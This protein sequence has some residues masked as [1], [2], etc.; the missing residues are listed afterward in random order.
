MSQVEGQEVIGLDTISCV[1]ENYNACSFYANTLV[2]ET[3][4]RN[5]VIAT[6]GTEKFMKA[7]AKA[8]I[9][10]NE[11]DSRMDV[12]SILCIREKDKYSCDLEEYEQP[13]L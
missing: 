5:F 4:N 13:V 12:T 6:D 10:V 7:L 8:S 2:G 9:A 3:H 1:F 11:D